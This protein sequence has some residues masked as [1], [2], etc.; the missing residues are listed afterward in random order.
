MIITAKFLATPAYF[1]NQAIDA[2][3]LS[4]TPPEPLPEDD[5]SRCLTG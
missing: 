5:I 4:Y 3:K 2:M 1:H